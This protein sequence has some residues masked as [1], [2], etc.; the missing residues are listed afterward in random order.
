M[1]AVLANPAD[2]TRLEPLLARD[3][4]PEAL[5]LGV[6]VAYLWCPQGVIASRLWGRSAACSATPS[7]PATGPP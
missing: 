1:V 2:R 6:R 4:A 5:A 3:W 7:P